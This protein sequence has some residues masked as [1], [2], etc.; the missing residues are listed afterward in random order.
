MT[1]CNHTLYHRDGSGSLTGTWQAEDTEHGIRIACRCGKFYGYEGA[2]PK[3]P[4]ETQDSDVKVIK[5]P[6][7]EETI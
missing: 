7:C 3:I 1:D 6:D 5:S 4:R 2:L